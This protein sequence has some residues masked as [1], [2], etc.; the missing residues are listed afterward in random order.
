MWRKQQ[1]C[2]IQS[3]FVGPSRSATILSHGNSLVLFISIGPTTALHIATCCHQTQRIERKSRAKK[4]ILIANCWQH[5]LDFCLSFDVC[6][7]SVITMTTS[8]S[9]IHFLFLIRCTRMLS[10]VKYDDERN[11][12]AAT[13]QVI[14]VRSECRMPQDR[15]ES[16]S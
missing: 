1:Y 7:C 2:S 9:Q 6:I 14:R 11:Q 3:N 5:A 13:P 4:W 10:G 8:S 16:K 15:S 12:Q